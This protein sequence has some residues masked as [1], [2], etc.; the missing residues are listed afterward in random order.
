MNFEN[1]A[2]PATVFASAPPVSGESFESGVD[3]RLAWK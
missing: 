1:A 3:I 2:A